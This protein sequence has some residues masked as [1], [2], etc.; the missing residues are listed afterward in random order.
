MELCLLPSSSLSLVVLSLPVSS[1]FLFWSFWSRISS[2]Y[3]TQTNLKLPMYCRLNLNLP[4]HPPNCMYLMPRHLYPLEKAGVLTTMSW[5]MSNTLQSGW[6]CMNLCRDYGSM[7]QCVMKTKSPV[8]DHICSHSMFQKMLMAASDLGHCD[9]ELA[10][11]HSWV[12][13][14]AT[15]QCLLIIVFNH[16]VLKLGSL[17]V[18][19]TEV[20]IFKQCW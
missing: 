20:L 13:W 16:L 5:E 12:H 19:S 11:P 2:H 3:V 14:I 15:N 7:M 18:S 6:H 1:F 17:S 4:H 10:C 9:G 8:Q